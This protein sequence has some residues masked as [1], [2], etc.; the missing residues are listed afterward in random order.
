MVGNQIKNKIKE[1]GY[2]LKFIAEKLGLTPYGLAL[3]LNGKNEF[4]W[5]EILEISNILNLD[6]KEKKEIFFN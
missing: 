6:E 4:K 3:K 1:K 2:K 5:S